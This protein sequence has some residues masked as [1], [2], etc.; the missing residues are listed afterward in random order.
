MDASGNLYVGIYNFNKIIKIT[1]AGGVSDYA[2][3]IATRA[4][5]CF[6]L[7]STRA[8]TSTWVSDADVSD[9][10]GGSPVTPILT[11]LNEAVGHVR[12]SGDN[13]IIGQYGFR[14]LIYASPTRG[15]PPVK[16]RTPRSPRS[17]GWPDPVGGA[18]RAGR[19]SEA[20]PGP[21]VLPRQRL[22][23]RSPV[24]FPGLAAR[25]RA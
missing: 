7:N 11:G 23:R 3:G 24:L 6:S 22:Q 21:G 10:P 17:A 9:R 8:A 5:C 25:G 15:N 19:R 14:T 12:W 20:L 1:P 18:V 2:T 13:F 16:L 4:K